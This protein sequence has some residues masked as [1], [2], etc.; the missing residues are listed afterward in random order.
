METYQPTTLSPEA[1][2]ELKEIADGEIPESMTD[3]EIEEM[4]VNLLKCFKLTR[5]KDPSVAG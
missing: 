3:A 5:E 4:R 2:E 1:F